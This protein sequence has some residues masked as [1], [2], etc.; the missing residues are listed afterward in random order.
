[1]KD[2]ERQTNTLTYQELEHQVQA[3]ASH[4]QSISAPGKRALLQ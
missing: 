1:M 3:I 2:G 4:L